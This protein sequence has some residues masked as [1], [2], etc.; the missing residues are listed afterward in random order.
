MAYKTNVG[1]VNPVTMKKALS[2]GL[3]RVIAAEGDITKYDTIVGDGDCG[4]GLKR[5]AEGILRLLDIDG[6]SDDLG[7]NMAQ[8]VAIIETTMD[9]TSGALY[10]IFLNSLT[11]HLK[12]QEGSSPSPATSSI[13]AKALSSSLNALGKYTPAQPGDRTLMDALC[14]FVEILGS[15]GNIREAAEAAKTG[16]GSTKGMQPKLGRTVYIGG[17]GWENVPDPGAYGL[18]EFLTGLAEGL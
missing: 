15:T 10:A 11:L 3:K 5:G 8:I 7:V 2:Y 14:P 4:V 12:E 6:L 17:K 1:P 13:W 9:G 16:A 18:S